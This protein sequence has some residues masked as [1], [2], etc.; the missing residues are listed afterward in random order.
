MT[1]LNIRG[2]ARL[3]QATRSLVSEHLDHDVSMTCC[4][5]RDEWPD[6]PIREH[7]D[8]CMSSAIGY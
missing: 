5:P 4:A 7:A 6:V 2:A 1:G 8:F 3:E